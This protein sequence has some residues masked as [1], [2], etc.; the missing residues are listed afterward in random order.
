MFDGAV[1]K[2]HSVRECSEPPDSEHGRRSAIL[3]DDS[4]S[5]ILGPFDDLRRISACEVLF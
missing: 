4:F 3:V 5:F 1:E 2:F